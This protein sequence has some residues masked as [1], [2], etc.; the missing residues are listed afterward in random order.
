VCGSPAP[1]TGEG[2][3]QFVAGGS[4]ASKRADREDHPTGPGSDRG[5]EQI[6]SLH[7]MVLPLSILPDIQLRFSFFLPSKPTGGSDFQ[8]DLRRVAAYHFQFDR[9]VEVV[10]IQIV[11]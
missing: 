4:P 9:V 3:V 7:R 1:Y 5:F 2:D 10:L 8:I 11:G 6:T